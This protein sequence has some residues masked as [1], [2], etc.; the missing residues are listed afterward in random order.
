MKNAT[1]VG[2]H[3]NSKAMKSCPAEPREKGYFCNLRVEHNIIYE[4]F[5][6]RK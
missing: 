1:A 6:L 5:S 2:L 3:A 4:F